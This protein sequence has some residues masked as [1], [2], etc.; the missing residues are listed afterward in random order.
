[1][2]T[3]YCEIKPDDN[4]TLLVTFPEL[5]GCVTFG[6]SL[7]EALT[8]ALDAL[9]TVLESRI[10]HGEPIPKPRVCEGL[11]PVRVPEY[12]EVS[13]LHLLYD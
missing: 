5:D 13:V 1:M 2:L 9:V 3:Y 7:E 6:E 4:H 10:E 8:R 11:Y 12:L